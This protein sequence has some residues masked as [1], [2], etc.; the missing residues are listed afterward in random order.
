MKYIIPIL[1]LL[2]CSTTKKQR[3]VNR[4]FTDSSSVT[5]IDS[6]ALKT[7]D[8]ST[9]KKDNTVTIK[10]TDGSYTKETVI[11]FDTAR[12]YPPDPADYFPPV[13]RIKITE[14]GV[15]KEI[16]TTKANTSDSSRKI[17]TDRNE[18]TKTVKT[19]LVK[20]QTVKKVD[21]KRVSYWGWLWLVPLLIILIIIYRYR[22]QIKFFIQNIKL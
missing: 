4:S 6:N 19:D 11:E 20:T 5:K 14:T 17:S 7:V 1:I 3:S 9:V 2:S 18:L 8:S 10:Q 15:K 13:T 16:I 12:N 22:K 21:V